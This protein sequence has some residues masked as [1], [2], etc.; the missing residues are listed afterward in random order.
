VVNVG[1]ARVRRGK[2][3]VVE[4]LVKY[5]S[6][7]RTISGE[8]A[9]VVFTK[10][11]GGTVQMHQQGRDVQ[12]GMIRRDV[13]EI[14]DTRLTNVIL[15]RKPNAILEEAIFR[16]EPVGMVLSKPNKA[17]R[18]QVIAIKSPRD[19]FKQRFDAMVL[20]FL[21][22]MAI[23]TLAACVFSLVVGG[24]LAAVVSVPLGVIAAIVLFAYFLV[25][26][27][28]IFTRALRERNALS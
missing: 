8:P 26:T 17:K 14:G 23:M 27:F 11:L 25:P 24:I 10:G 9:R 13:L 6:D 22:S 7:P 18:Q 28:R 19:Y 21:I 3:M 15:Q 1:N 16:N 2:N 20:A 12:R 5:T 4:G